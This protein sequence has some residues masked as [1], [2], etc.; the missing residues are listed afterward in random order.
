MPHNLLPRDVT[1]VRD[2]ATGERILEIVARGKR[3]I[4]HYKSMPS[5]VLPYQRLLK[6]AKP[7]ADGENGRQEGEPAPPAK[8]SQYTRGQASRSIGKAT[9]A[10]RIASV[11]LTS[12]CGSWRGPT[13]IKSGRTAAPA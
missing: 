7:L 3:G 13:F 9:H 2:H 4:G 11:T 10:R 1:I 12:A 8:V 5:A 6:R